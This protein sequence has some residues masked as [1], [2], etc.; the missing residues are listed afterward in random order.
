MSKAYKLLTP[1]PL[2]TTMTVKQAMLEDR[3]TWDDDYKQ[4]VQWIR[5]KLLEIGQA[6]S[7]TY[8]TVLMQGS[9]TFGVEATI[10]SAVSLE[11]ELLIVANGAYGER[12]AEI[13]RAKGI[14]FSVLAFP[15]NEAIDA[16]AVDRHLA[17]RPSIDDVAFV[18]CETTTGVWN[19]LE[20][21]ATVVKSHGKR[22]IVDAMSSFGG[23]PIEIERCGIDYLVSS[24]NKCIQGVPG[25]SFVICK[26]SEIALCEGNSFSLALDLYD[27]WRVLEKQGGKWRYT[28]PT[29]VVLAFRQALIELEAEG[30]VVERFGRYA[31]NQRVLA[32]RMGALGFRAY[33]DAAVQSPTIT[34]FYYPDFPFFT[35][36]SYYEFLKQAG[37]VI[38]PGKL[39]DADVFRVGTIGDVDEEDI[40][41]LC[42]ATE[43]YIA[44]EGVVR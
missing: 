43:R 11:S 13:A 22:L 2:S 38:Y 27:Q 5:A 8:T 24:S 41:Q 19:P 23:I 17:E 31:R 15:T 36:E 34:T 35:F 12:M 9:G 25:F 20:E 26:K 7:E 30:G 39:M 37:F 28:S 32:E 3:C 29:H 6:G 1:G 40:R 42:A 44:W 21:L 10:G 16:A 14:R 33:L 4:V 18:H